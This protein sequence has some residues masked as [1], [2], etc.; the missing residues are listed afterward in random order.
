MHPL[1]TSTNTLVERK[2]SLKRNRDTKGTTTATTSTKT[3]SITPPPLA[4]QGGVYDGPSFSEIGGGRRNRGYFSPPKLLLIVPIVIIIGGFFMMPSYQMTGSIFTA[5][6][7]I[8]G[9]SIIALSWAFLQFLIISQIPIQ[10][11]SPDASTHTARQTAR[12]NEIYEAIY[13]GAEC[14]LR[15]EYTVCLCFIVFFAIVIMVLVTWGTGMDYVRGL[16]T[17]LSFIFG[18]LTSMASGY[19]G[20]KIAVFSNVRTTISAQKLGWTAW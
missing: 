14:F 4:A 20:M 11:Y 15:A 5:T 19:F 8:V 1:T 2:S 6:G 10:S 17:T 18:A 3:M 16:F 7:F 9:S 13:E 12:L